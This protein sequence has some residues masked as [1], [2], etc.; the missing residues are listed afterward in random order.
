MSNAI[1]RNENFRDLLRMFNTNVD[2]KYCL[3]VALT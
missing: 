3:C 2:G 1:V